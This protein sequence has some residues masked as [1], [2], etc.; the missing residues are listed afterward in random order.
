MIRAKSIT[1]NEF[2]GIRN[3]TLNLD[4]K[5]FAVCGPN[6]TGKSGIVDALEFAL[7]GNISRLSGSGTGGLSVKEHGPHVDS[8]NNPE[9]AFVSLTLE[10][11]SIKKVV[12]I[13]RTVKDARNPTITPNDPDVIEVLKT[14]ALHPEFVLSRRELIRYVLSEPGKRSKEVQELLR[15]EE[16]EALRALFQKI[17]NA[18]ERDVKLFTR[19]RDDA[20]VSLRQAL[21]MPQLTA[22]AILAAANEK[23]QLLSLPLLTILEAN[24]SIKDGIATITAAN[25]NK[26]SKIQAITDIT[27]IKQSLSQLQSPE[28]IAECLAVKTAL[29]LMVKD[30]EFLQHSTREAL[31]KNAL[32]VFDDKACPVCDTPWNPDDFRQHLAYKLEHYSTITQQR[33]ELEGKI[34]PIAVL[35]GSIQASLPTIRRYGMQLTTPIEIKPLTDYLA[36]LKSISSALNDFLPLNLSIQVLS[37]LDKIPVQV[38]STI[39]NIETAVGLLPEATQQ[40]AARDFLTIGQERLEMYRQESL[41]LKVAEQKLAT[42]KV[43]FETYGQVTTDALES[44]YNNVQELFSKLYRLINHDDEAQFQAQLKPSIGK[45]GFDVDFYGRGFFPPGAYHS[46]GHQDGMGLCLY[47]ALMSYLAGESFTFAVLDDVLMSV[48]SG[49]RREVSKMLREQ[50]PNT[51]FLLTTHDEIWL[52]HMKTVGLIESKNSAHFRTWDVAS[53]PTEWDDRDIWGEIFNSLSKN[54]VRAA[55]AALRNYLEYLSKELCHVLRAP[56]E[57]RGDAQY[58]LGELL[59]NAISKFKKLLK[60]GKNAAQS[61]GQDDQ[62]SAIAEME[63]RF[64]AAVEESKVEQWAINSAVHYNEWANFHSNDFKPVAKAFKILTEAFTC[65]ECS[66]IFFV[67]PIQAEPQGLRCVC[68]KCN[69]NLLGKH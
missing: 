52:K 9:K 57:F 19:N 30:E 42:A 50:F 11:E 44:I 20:G 15:L 16:V 26:I 67:T 27:D 62:L 1:V 51:Q 43:V 61:W 23:R 68:G 69:I 5:N 3:I 14:V 59:P 4:G 18:C 54:D 38:S 39:Q 40:D 2:R 66:S 21:N 31:L 8:R 41:K 13:L 46:E 45:L 24:T 7:T 48:D 60:A 29:E 65:L 33:K 47:L 6:G 64:N 28:F 17:A 10:I 63:Q 12:T 34:D 55:S 56:V 36:E 49:H 25:T 53:G 32:E 35:I 37:S 58:S 22:A